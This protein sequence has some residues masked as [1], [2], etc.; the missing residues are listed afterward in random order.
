[1]LYAQVIKQRTGGRITAIS[2]HVVFGDPAVVAARL[3]QSPVSQTINTSFV[4]RDNLTQRQQNR[5]LTRRT[6]GFSKALSGFEKQLWLSLAYYPFVL[7]HDSL[8]H[9]R[10]ITEP[11]RGSGSPRRWC[12][13]TPAMAAGVTDPVW[14]TQELLSY[15]VSPLYWTECPDLEKLFR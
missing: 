14:T 13:S 1:M 5:R 3:A 12:P 7:P 4:E 6:N 2:T 8:R 15:R 9:P 10:P 11:T